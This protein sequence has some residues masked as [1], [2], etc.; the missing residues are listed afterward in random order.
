M[1][2]LSLHFRRL[3]FGVLL[4]IL[5]YSGLAR[6]ERLVGSA[7]ADV[8]FVVEQGGAVDLTPPGAYWDWGAYEGF[9]FDIENVGDSALETL[10]VVHSQEDSGRALVSRRSIMLAARTRQRL[11]FFFTNGNAGPY[12]GMRGIP[13]YYRLSALPFSEPATTVNPAR[14]T[15]V[16]IG[17][18]DEGQSSALRLYD[19]TLFAS[20]S[21]LA[22]LTPHPFIDAFGQFKHEHWP[23]KA[24]DLESLTQ[25]HTAEAERLRSTSHPASQDA[26]GGW[27][28][29]PQLDA[30]GWFR[31]AQVKGK[32]W[33]VTPEGRL[34]LSLGVNC[35]HY[36]NSTFITGREDWFEGL[37]ELDGAGAAFW[38]QRSGVHSLAEAI[39]GEGR[40]FNHYGLNLWRVYGDDYRARAREKAYQRLR[41]WGFTTIGN[42]SDGEIVQRSPL[43][44][45]ATAYSG[46]ARRLDG[47]AGYWGKMKDVYDPVFQEN[48][49]KAIARAAAPYKDNPLVVGF[50]VD[51][52]MSWL[53]IAQGALLSPEDQPARQVFVALLRETHGNLEGVNAAWKTDAEDWSALRVP[54]SPTRQ[55]RDDCAVFEYGFARRYFETV[56]TALRKHAPN[57]LYLGCRFT[58]VYC[59]APALQ[60]CAEIVDVVS[61]NLYAREVGA[62]RYLDL[63]KPVIFGEFHFGATDRGMFHTGLQGA[64][65][66]AE[67]AVLYAGYVERLAR[68]P[69]TIGA[70]WFQY[71]DQPTTGRDLDGENYNIGLVSIVDAP[72]PELIEAATS[73]HERMYAIRYED[74]G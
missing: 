73:I 55:C 52:E 7:A 17:V 67:R 23:G 3:V 64:A 47:G 1:V 54:A 34:F 18:A 31:V 13:V 26:L 8:R 45:T 35:I 58:P 60:A 15:G 36:G 68:H 11:P 70:H 66:Q 44:F 51:N 32:W 74:N 42:W 59:P 30:T 4:G 61:I 22:Q 19:I 27:L 69:A 65:T 62:D 33:F 24:L 43:P 29:G 12:W 10:I 72:Y 21:A 50:F 2:V 28:D 9:S 40:V 41:A 14:T 6:A 71:M 63:G 37:P 56:A 49:D 57:H 48:T 39:G 25:S 5:L 16:A 20:G 53:N 38:G 46:D